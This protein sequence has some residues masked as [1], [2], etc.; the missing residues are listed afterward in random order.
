MAPAGT[1]GSNAVPDGPP[2]VL[3]DAGGHTQSDP[4]GNRYRR[5]PPN[6][7][8]ESLSTQRGGAWGCGPHTYLR[9]AQPSQRAIDGIRPT[10]ETGWTGAEAG[11]LER[12]VSCRHVFLLCK[13]VGR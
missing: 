3:L 13:R 12:G 7:L 1:H 11:N 4:S 8:R 2:K 5:L 6:A 9:L 10:G